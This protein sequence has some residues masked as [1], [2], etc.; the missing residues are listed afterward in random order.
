MD[1]GV[2]VPSCG[3]K[4][5][6]TRSVFETNAVGMVGTTTALLIILYYNY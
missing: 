5:Y 3:P 2:N 6:Y 1:E 4:N